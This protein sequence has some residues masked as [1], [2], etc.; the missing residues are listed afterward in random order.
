MKFFGFGKKNKKDASDRFSETE[1]PS[2][3]ERPSEGEGPSEFE[4]FLSGI[5]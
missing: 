2:E 3:L 1:R 5:F 4:D